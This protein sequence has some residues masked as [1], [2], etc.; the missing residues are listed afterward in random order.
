MWQLSKE[1]AKCVYHATLTYPYM[2][3]IEI[4]SQMRRAS[5]SVASNIA[6]GYRQRSRHAYARY[7]NIAAGSNAELE[8]QLDLVRELGIG[9]PEGVS[10]MAALCHR[11]GRMLNAL[12]SRLES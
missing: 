10:E 9:D 6:E 2:H 3:R 1:L 7:L 5:V 11:V 4:G 8:T 12:V